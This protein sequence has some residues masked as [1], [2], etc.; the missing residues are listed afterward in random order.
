MKKKCFIII[1]IFLL[2]NGCSIKKEDENLT[3]PQDI[4]KTNNPY[5][6]SSFNDINVFE[7]FVTLHVD[8]EMGPINTKYYFHAY[9]NGK[10]IK[11][12]FDKDGDK[13]ITQEL[14]PTKERNSYTFYMKADSFKKGEKVN[15]GYGV[16]LNPDY[17]PDIIE[18]TRYDITKTNVS[19]FYHDFNVDKSYNGNKDGINVFNNLKWIDLNVKD[20]KNL[21][22]PFLLDSDK[23]VI[24]KVLHNEPVNDVKVLNAKKENSFKVY[25]AKEGLD[26]NG[27]ITFYI[28]HKPIMIGKGYEAA[29][30]DFSSDNY[31]MTDFDLEIPKDITSGYHTFYAIIL[32]D[33]NGDSSNFYSTPQRVLKIE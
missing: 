1:C 14:T 2:M 4:D 6:M 5:L 16:I 33:G 22:A 19:A 21:I 17:I 26:T 28:D 27:V 20:D 12:S 32:K 11:F 10:P 23:D 31:S 18:Y 9:Q 8:L 7:D 30:L 29:R 13:K 3:L 24:E 25:I 15:F